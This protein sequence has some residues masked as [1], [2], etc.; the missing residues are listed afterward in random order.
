M[1]T[2]NSHRR[3]PPVCLVVAAALALLGRLRLRRQ[4][5]GKVVSME[6]GR[7]FQAFRHL[8]RRTS[9]DGATAVLVIRFKFKR[10]SQGLNRLL[11][12]IPVPM[13]GGFPGFRDK[14]WM[15]DEETG[16]WQGVYEWES[17]DAVEQYRGS[18]VLAAMIRRAD[19]SSL[20]YTTI[21]R[22]RLADFLDKRIE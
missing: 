10:F 7:R 16:E 13:I 11:S 1:R 3:L 2:K 15:V 19:P 6:D 21:P 22:I 20:S 5:V 9:D 12:L 18:F 4:Y 8:S 14:V 17:A